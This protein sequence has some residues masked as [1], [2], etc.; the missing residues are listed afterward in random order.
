MKSVFV[1]QHE[2]EWCGSD[3]VKF[4]GVY[5][6]REDAETTT[7]RLRNQPEFCDW[8]DGFSIEEYSLNEDHWAEGFSTMVIIL[9]RTTS[10]HTSYVAAS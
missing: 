10:P 5:S 4:I 9:V 1:L 8:P 2:Y 6:T 7:K 3:E